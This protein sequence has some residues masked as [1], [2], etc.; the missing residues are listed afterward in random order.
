MLG[1]ARTLL[2]LSAYMVFAVVGLLAVAVML[3]F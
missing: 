2:F 1:T 3:V